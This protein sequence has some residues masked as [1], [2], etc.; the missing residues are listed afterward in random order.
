VRFP[1][2]HGGL[3]HKVKGEVAIGDKVR[4]VFKEKSKRTGSIL[5]IEHF[6]KIT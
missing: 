5:D 1:S 3:V 6:E 2:A 4:V